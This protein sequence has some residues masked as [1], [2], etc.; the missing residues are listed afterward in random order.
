[1]DDTNDF[2]PQGLTHVATLKVALL[3]QLEPVRDDLPPEVV[4]MIHEQSEKMGDLVT[5][6]MAD[7]SNRNTLAQWILSFLPQFDA[8]YS[9]DTSTERTQ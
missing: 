2:N 8:V 4:T 7:E 5:Y 1:M 3:S 6:I 9:R